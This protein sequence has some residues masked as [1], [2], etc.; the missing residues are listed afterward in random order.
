RLH[1]MD[2]FGALLRV[3]NDQDTSMLRHTAL[4]DHAN[5]RLRHHVAGEELGWPAILLAI[6]LHPRVGFRF[7]L[8]EITLEHLGHVA[9]H[10]PLALGVL[11]DAAFA[12]YTFGHENAAHAG[13][14]DHAGGMELHELHVDQLGAGCVG[15][16]VAV[17]RVLPRIARDLPRLADAAG[18]QDD[19]AGAKQDEAAR[20]AEVAECSGHS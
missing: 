9:E 11:E 6:A 16:R 14:P 15:E 17:P 4:G 12:A 20:F 13:W 3:D 10:E 19:G 5:D 2:V 7:R 18:R 8:G 1:L